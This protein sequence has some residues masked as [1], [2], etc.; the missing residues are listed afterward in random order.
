MAHSAIG[1]S[2]TIQPPAGGVTAGN[3]VRGPQVVRADCRGHR[4][5]HH[6]RGWRAEAQEAR[7][8]I[9][10]DRLLW[11]LG[12]GVGAAYCDTQRHLQ[13]TKLPHNAK[14]RPRQ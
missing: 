7:I 14:E 1:G 2:G 13:K 9:V 5:D 12:L 3:I 6:Q 8:V 10:V 4:E 11:P